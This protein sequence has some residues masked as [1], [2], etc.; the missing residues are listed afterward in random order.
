M[1]NYVK[2]RL[3]DQD[4]DEVKAKQKKDLVKTKRSISPLDITCN[5]LED[6]KGY[7]RCNEQYVR[8]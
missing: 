8:R 4:R 5:I 2:E 6:S 3:V 7:V 1:K